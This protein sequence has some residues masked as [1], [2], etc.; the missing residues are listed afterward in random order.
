[1]RGLFE[2]AHTIKSG[3]ELRREL[4]EGAI[5]SRARSDQGNMVYTYMYVYILV[6][7]RCIYFS[8]QSD[9][10]YRKTVDSGTPSIVYDRLST[11]PMGIETVSASRQRIG[12]LSCHR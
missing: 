7:V 9:A 12:E 5:F 11:E 1:M 8:S 6:V 10:V 4:F 3:Q 2:G